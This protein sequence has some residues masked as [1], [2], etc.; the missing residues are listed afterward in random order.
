MI[1][2]IASRAIRIRPHIVP[3]GASGP[4]RFFRSAPAENIL[5][6]PVRIATCTSSRSLSASNVAI[7]SSISAGGWALTG[8]LSIVTTAI[9]SA[10]SRRR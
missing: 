5:P 9:L 1:A 2:Y 6:V 4:G 3:G 10:T 7:T 8:G